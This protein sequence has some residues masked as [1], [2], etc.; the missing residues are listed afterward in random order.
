LHP[1]LSTMATG[2]MT[3]ESLLRIEGLNVAATGVSSPRELLHDVSFTIEAGGITAIIGESGSGKTILT[4]ALTNLFPSKNIRVEGTVTFDGSNLLALRDRQLRTIR[5]TSIRYVFQEPA[6]SLNPLLLLQLQASQALSEQDGRQHYSEIAALCLQMG[7]AEPARA[8]AAYPHQLSVGTLQRAIIAMGMLGHPKLIIADE[9]T[10]A[11]DASQRFQI[12]DLFYKQCR[13]RGMALLL[14]THDVEIARRYADTMIVLH[15]GRIVECAPAD[16]FFRNPLHGKSAALLSD[17][18]LMAGR[19]AGLHAGRITDCARAS[20]CPVPLLEVKDLSVASRRPSFS[21]HPEHRILRSVSFALD[22][23]VTMGLIGESGSGKTTLARCIAGLVRP[24]AGTIS[25]TGVNIFPEM[26][27][28]RE[29]GTAIQLVFQNYSDSL[30]PR[31]DIRSALLEGMNGHDPEEKLAELCLM[32]ALPPEILQRFPRELSGGQRQR[33]VLARALAVSPKLLILDE[34]T[35]ALDP[36][37]Q[38]HIVE[39]IRR[40]RQLT[41]V[42]ILYISHDLRTSAL[43]CEKLLVLHNGTIV[44]GGETARILRA[45]EHDYTRQ[46]VQAT[47]A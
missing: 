34:P 21:R 36:A 1:L 3:K 9:P 22:E 46:I 31:L 42:A 4:R 2:D 26:Q 35:S 24:A 43:L 15:S 39:T 47:F 13:T 37:T 6:S 38:L 14:T 41:G 8:M 40:I 5:R 29:L 45:P 27:N 7:V 17:V 16:A 11:I 12:L 44:E 10:S 30:D 18:Q 28:R 32:M 33:V 25:V 19:E 23:G 20:G